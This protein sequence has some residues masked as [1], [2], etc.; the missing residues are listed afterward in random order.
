[1][2]RTISTP[3]VASSIS[4]AFVLASLVLVA[5]AHQIPMQT[6]DRIP[7]AQGRV[8]ISKADNDNTKMKLEVAHLADPQKLAAGATAYVVWIQSNP[9]QAQNVGALAV[10]DNR[11]AS[12]ETVTPHRDFQLFVTAEPAATVATPT[13]ERLLFA[14][15]R[16]K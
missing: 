13:S 15:V 14:T 5:C 12:L 4:R 11:Q 2:T 6:S 3:P 7:A 8:E 9:G 16:R 10:G 1:M